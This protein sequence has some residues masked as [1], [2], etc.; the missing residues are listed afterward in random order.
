MEK[1]KQLKRLCVEYKGGELILPPGHIVY[2]F[3]VKSGKVYECKLEKKKTPI[4]L[5]VKQLIM[6]NQ[7]P[8]DKKEVFVVPDKGENF[9]QIFAFDI[10][11]ARVKFKNYGKSIGVK[12]KFE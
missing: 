12:V 11:K 3:D 2:E 1:D 9:W 10:N 5:K 7:Y 4:D 6:P 8:K